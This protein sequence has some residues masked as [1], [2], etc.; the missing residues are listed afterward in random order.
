MEKSTK[1]NKKN[2]AVS[3]EKWKQNSALSKHNLESSVP[4]FQA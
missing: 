3:V 1:R 4:N 2:C